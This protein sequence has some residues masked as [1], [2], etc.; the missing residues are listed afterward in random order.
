[1]SEELP[2]LDLNDALDRVD[3][4]RALYL[5]LI[6]MFFGDWPVSL[7]TLKRELEAKNPKAFSE[8]AHAA[9]GV[10]GNISAR[11]AHAA[12]YVL[13]KI[14][15]SGDLTN[16]RAELVTLENEVESFRAEYQKLKADV[17]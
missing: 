4:D 2:V 15:K 7:A 14:G 3:G 9:K 5:E 16:A 1:M 11:R 6:E 8:A 12:A 10:L 17:G 13:E